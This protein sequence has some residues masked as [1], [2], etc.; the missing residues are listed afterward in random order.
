MTGGRCENY[1][2]DKH[3]HPRAAPSSYTRL[4]MKTAAGIG[5]LLLSAGVF[6]QAQSNTVDPQTEVVR[7]YCAGCHSERGKAGGLSLASFDAA[8]AA[9]HADVSEKMI[10]K[11]RA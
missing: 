2:A 8:A 9:Q 3:V 7:Q 4:P 11:L 10:R 1:P 5:I 6:G